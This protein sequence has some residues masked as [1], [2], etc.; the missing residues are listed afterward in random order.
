MISARDLKKHYRVHERPP[1]VAAAF[2]SLFKRS[3][4]TVEAV[5]GITFEIARGE[6]V[7]FLGPNGAGK[8]TTLKMLA[9]L[10]HP[11]SGSISVDGHEPKKRDDAFLQSIMLVTGQKQQLLWDLPPSETFELNR[12]V[13]GVS[14][15]QFKTTMT[16]LTE[17]LEI[18]DVIKRPT[19]QLSLGERMKCE[20]AAALVHSPKVLFLDEPTIGLD[21]TMQVTI[22]R[23]IRDYNERHG[24]TLILTSHDMDDVHALCPRV[25]VIDKGQLSYDGSLDALATKLRPEKRI[26]LHLSAPVD[27]DRARALGDIVEQTDARLVL[28]VPHT[29]IAETVA[30]A[31]AAFSV[32]D[33]TVE[34]PP[35]EDVMR[36]LFTRSRA[37]RQNEGA[38]GESQ[39]SA[40]PS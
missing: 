13:Y 17:L 8:T 26:A 40:E 4:R 14:R 21:V 18:G 33:L 20:L 36:E 9:G 24:A 25:V 34:N 16:E 35:L 6:R 27:A 31:L 10:L 30:K 37:A 39:A 7:G 29:N 12:A 1:G 3:Y 2:A 23:F 22:R 11:T 28:Q 38:R 15:E 19:R 32:S 5:D